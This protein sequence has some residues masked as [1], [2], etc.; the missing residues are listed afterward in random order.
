MLNKA[1]ALVY[2]VL[3]VKVI[4]ILMQSY[5]HKRATNIVFHLH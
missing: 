2:V 5:A 4:V 3:S 1:Q